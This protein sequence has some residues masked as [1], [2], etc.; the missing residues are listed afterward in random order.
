MNTKNR[1][2]IFSKKTFNKTGTI[3]ASRKFST[4]EEARQFK[5]TQADGRTWGIYD[6]WSGSTVR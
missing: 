5:R 2:V 3:K 1:Y 6:I 4:R